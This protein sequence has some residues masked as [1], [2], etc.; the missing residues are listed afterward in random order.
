[1]TNWTIL[2]ISPTDDK[3]A[4]RRAYM[5]QL[6]HHNPEDDPEGFT[7]LRT[8]YEQIL[9]AL[10]SPHDIK[11]AE[12]TSPMGLFLGR[13]E[14]VYNH[15]DSRRNI[16][17]WKAL[18]KDEV[19][20]RLDLEDAAGEQILVFLMSHHYLPHQVWMLLD[21]YFGW[22]AK[23]TALKQIFPAHYIDFVISSSQYEGLRYDLFTINPDYLGVVDASQYNR[24]IWLY[25][26]IEALGHMPDHPSVLAMRQEIE[27][28]PIKHV[29][30]DLQL[31]RM[32]LSKEEPEEKAREKTLAAALAITEPIYK[33][34]PA[35]TKVIYAHAYVL[36]TMGHSSQAL[37]LFESILAKE[38]ENFGAKKGLIEA[39][40]A[41]GDYEPARHQLLEVLDKH[42]YNLFALHFFKLVTEKLTL[43][44]EEK[45]A[46]NPVDPETALTLAKHYLNG[47]QYDK[48]REILEG[49]AYDHS[50]Y[51]E[52]LADCYAAAGDADKAI[53]FYEKNISLEKKYRN[54]VKFIT[55]LIDGGKVE[56]ALEVTEE[57]LLLDDNDK[58]S[59][60]YLHDNRGLIFH[61]LGRYQDALDAYGT[62]IQIN[63]QAAHIHIH[64]AQTFKHMQRYSEALDCCEQAIAIF[65]YTTEAYTIQMEIYYESALYDQMLELSDKADQVGFESPRVKYHKA[66]AL[67]MQG[68]LDQAKTLLSKLLDA[69]FDEGYRDFFQAE[70]DICISQT[71]PEDKPAAGFINK[72]KKITKIFANLCFTVFLLFTF[73]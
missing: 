35:D 23:E 28:L 5:S 67:R 58:L 52:Y 47:Y 6:P 57:A 1:M 55:T 66:R 40:I 20:M 61:Q 53:L 3:D 46:K 15:F 41:L 22:K 12:D 37:S 54:F 25:Y 38:Q 19:C 68:N 9:K 8:A 26:E 43:I 59:L 27:T 31:V 64:K 36:L 32:L 10:N 62:G 14:G 65:P 72:I 24:W 13:L 48:C 42:P 33:A 7:R 50:R 51:Y 18:L 17:A 16:E 69:E 60:A 34:L 49:K 2:N 4:V 45:Y 30:Y 11:D 56:R 29:Y 21:G 63:S 73:S 39:M 44:Y 71:H 70:L